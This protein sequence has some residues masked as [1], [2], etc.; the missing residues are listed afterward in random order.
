MFFI[1]AIVQV[2]W[3]MDINDNDEENG[4]IMLP[5]TFRGVVVHGFGR[6]GKKLNCPTGLIEFIYLFQLLF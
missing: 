4:R 6:G 5:Y 2:F 3:R 1:S